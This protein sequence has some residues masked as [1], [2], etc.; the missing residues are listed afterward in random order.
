MNYAVIKYIYNTNRI[1]TFLQAVAGQEDHSPPLHSSKTCKG[2]IQL[3]YEKVPQQY[4]LLIH[5]S[6]NQERIKL[7]TSTA[8][9]IYL[10]K[11]RN[12][13]YN[14]DSDAIKRNRLACD[15]KYNTNLPLVPYDKCQHVGSPSVKLS[16]EFSK[17]SG[18]HRYVFT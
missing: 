1:L 9:Y 7:S 10:F 17:T 18:K 12:Q 11:L 3:F 8:Q 13:Q 2:L 5:D 15:T 6:L 14:T 16:G 4:G